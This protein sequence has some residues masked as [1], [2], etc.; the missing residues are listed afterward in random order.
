MASRGRFIDL[1]DLLLFVARIY[2]HLVLFAL[3]STVFL[4][5][6]SLD[7]STTRRNLYF[8]PLHTAERYI[9][10]RHSKGYFTRAGFVPRNRF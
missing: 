10:V 3:L 4:R 8:R 9:A 2:T 1:T 5:H 7:V 6:Q